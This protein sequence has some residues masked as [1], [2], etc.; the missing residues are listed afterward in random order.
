VYEQEP[1]PG[2]GYGIQL[3]PNAVRLLRR[4]G[5]EEFRAVRPERVRI[6]RWDDGRDL[7]TTPLGRACAD[8]FGAPYLTL[9]RSELLAALH[10]AVA[11]RP[12]VLLSYGSRCVRVDTGSLHLEDESIVGADLVVGADGLHS[13][14]RR[15][16]SPDQVRDSGITVHRGLICREWTYGVP[17]VCVWLGPGRHLAA[18]PIDRDRYS[19]VAAT[20]DPVESLATAFDGWDRGVRDLLAGAESVTRWE[21]RDRPPLRTW[22]TGSVTVI[23]DAAH[24][25]LPLGAHG[26]NQAIESAAALA[27]TVA[28]SSR[29]NLT[30]NLDRYAGVRAERIG[31]VVE[32][33]RHN[34]ADHHLADGPAQ[35]G[36]DEALRRQ[37]P[38]GTRA[39]LYGY[40]VEAMLSVA[41]AGRAVPAT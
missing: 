27:V 16:L 31:R 29:A 18:Y 23:G 17:E 41:L 28:G 13:V 12:E 9:P 14:V 32:L 34:A 7:A 40:D 6:R 38:L 10:R 26:A 30:T 25:M 20:V 21:L 11:R 2:Q 19:F 37:Q 4:A 8:R 36:R 5:V 35:R 15:A 24:A 22:H 3:A 1:T 33:V 39:W